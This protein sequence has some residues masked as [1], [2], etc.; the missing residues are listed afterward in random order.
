[1]P[2]PAAAPPPMTLDIF[3]A[4]LTE[5]PNGERWE[6]DAGRPVMNAQPTRRHDWIQTNILLALR[7]RW[8]VLRPAWRPSGPSQVP[9]PGADRTVAPDVL[10]APEARDD[11][12]VT[13]DPIAVFEI[14]SK[15]DTPRRQAAKRNAYEAVPSIRHYVLVRQDR[16]E[17]RAFGRNADGRLV[18]EPVDPDQG[19]RLT[20]LAVT[21]TLAE[22]YDETPLAQDEA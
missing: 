7:A 13:A 11:S 12:S 5:R 6:L 10:V 16:R 20:A 17:V 3:L 21:L 4:F 2:S 18:P 19:V 1:M 22:I 8:R 15:S 9:V 14:L